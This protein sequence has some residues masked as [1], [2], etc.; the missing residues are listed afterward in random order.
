MVMV[1]FFDT[2]NNNNESNQGTKR[3]LDLNIKLKQDSTKGLNNTLN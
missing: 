3:T 1:L 2:P